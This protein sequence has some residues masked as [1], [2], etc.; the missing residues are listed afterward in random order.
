MI[1]YVRKIIAKCFRNTI[2]SL[3]FKFK[4]KKVENAHKSELKVIRKKIINNEKIKVAFMLIHDS[5]WKCKL[6]Y[7]LMLKDEIF[8]PHIFVCPSVRCGEDIMKSTLNKTYEYFTQNNY[9]VSKTLQL[10][11]DWLNIKR[12]F[13]PDI[14][15]FTNPHFLTKKEYYINNFTDKLTCYVPY[16]I[17]TAN[18][19]Q[20]QYNQPFH[21]LLWKAFYETPIHLKMAKKYARNKGEN[22]VVSGYPWYDPFFDKNYKPKDHWKLKDNNVKRLIWAP[23][24]TLEDNKTILGYSEFLKY[25]NFIIDLLEHYKGKIQIAFKPHPLLKSKLYKHKD[26]GVEKTEAYYLKWKEIDNGQLEESDYVDLFMTS[27]GMMLDSVS[28][29]SEYVITNK[30]CLF[31]MRDETIGN[32]FNEFGA[33]AFKTL[34]LAHKKEDI[35]SFIDQTIMGN[36]DTRKTQREVFVNNYLKIENNSPS[37]NIY[38]HI[39]KSIYE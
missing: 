25:A 29:I 15:F 26:W 14:I 37:K 16:G 11:G 13:K 36:S 3:T 17:M 9:K 24:H 10:D 22:V 2:A 4:I 8:E 18:L 1:N 7:E 30:P 38:N 34:Y 35:I 6:L 39:L 28:F 33:L 20:L 19:Q 32:K 23:H 31:F 5:V 27:D 21:N 12:E